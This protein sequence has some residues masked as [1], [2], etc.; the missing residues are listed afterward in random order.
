MNLYHVTLCT[1]LYSLGTSGGNTWRPLLQPRVT[2]ATNQPTNQLHGAESSWETNKFSESP[3]IP[4]ISRN[5]TVHYRIH[6]RPP[7]V[8]ILS[9]I[10]PVRA[11]PFHFLKIYFNITL[12]STPRSSRLSPPLRSPHKNPWGN[13]PVPHTCH[14]SYQSHSFDL[15]TRITVGECAGCWWYEMPYRPVRSD[16]PQTLHADCVYMSAAGT[17]LLWDAGL[18]KCR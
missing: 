9:H 1:I 5:T 7:F 6:K 14:M 16:E 2:T 18:A 11:S 17:K 3:E 12:P 15:I 4:R 8:P 10:N 13:S